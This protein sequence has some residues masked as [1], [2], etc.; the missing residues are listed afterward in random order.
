LSNQPPESL[1][2]ADD[3][4]LEIESHFARVR[5]TT[6]LFSAKDWAL[7]KSWHEEGIPLSVVI[8][9]I[10]SCFSKRREA[11]RK[12]TISSLS[13]CRHAVQELWSD[14]KELYVGKGEQIPEREPSEE[15]GHLA[16]E[17]RHAATATPAFASLFE[18]AALEVEAATKRGSVPMI[19]QELL[20]IEQ[21]LLDAMQAGLEESDRAAIDAQLDEQ[22]RALRSDEP[23]AKRTRA[24]NLKR[25]LR[26][27]FG[28]PRLTLFR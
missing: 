14:R 19:E 2:P 8:E 9:A 5:E 11:G 17:L 1:V 3:Y 10:D 26:N 28:I 21:R 12:R 18:S 15:L 20:E 23:T 22:L 24:A 25:L 27:R 7:M 16:M 4:F 13:Y 6:F